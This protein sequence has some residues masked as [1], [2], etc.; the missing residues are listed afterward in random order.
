M[1]DSEKYYTSKCRLNKNSSVEAVDSFPPQEQ[2]QQSFPIHASA[3]R[4][5][6]IKEINSLDVH[7]SSRSA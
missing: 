4:V 3:R 7:A 6:R 5:K 1:R 2:N